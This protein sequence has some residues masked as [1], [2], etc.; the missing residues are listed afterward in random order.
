MAADDLRH[1]EHDALV[2][3]SA[4]AVDE[5]RQRIGERGPNLMGQVGVNLRRAGAAVPEDFLNDP[6]VHAGFQQMGRKRMSLMPRAA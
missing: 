2:V 4:E 3:R 6:Q 1:G 5:V